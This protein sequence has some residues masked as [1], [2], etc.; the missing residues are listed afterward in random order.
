MDPVD[1]S[2][3]SPETV[4]LAEE[5]LDVSKRAVT[6]GTVRVTT[7]TENVD[8]LV[9]E[10][11]ERETVEV[12]RVAVDREIDEVPALRVEGDV[13]IIPVTEEVLVVEKRLVLKEEIHLRRRRT[14]EVTEVSVPLRRQHADIERIEAGPTKL[15]N[16][17]E[18]LS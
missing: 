12:T 16:T 1:R 2:A 13:T 11:L 10:V 17:S 4:E 6:S 5:V 9:R 7:R 15:P 8:Q 3:V 14:S 18:D